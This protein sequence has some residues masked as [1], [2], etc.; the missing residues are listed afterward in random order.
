MSDFVEDNTTIKKYENE[1]IGEILKEE[2]FDYTYEDWINLP[3]IIP[4]FL[5]Y[6]NKRVNSITN[7][8]KEYL[9]LSNMIQGG[10]PIWDLI[11]VIFLIYNVYIEPT[12]RN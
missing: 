8:M 12:G 2:T 3:A 7:G 6:L 5:I 11:M 4:H 1:K 10:T 9:S